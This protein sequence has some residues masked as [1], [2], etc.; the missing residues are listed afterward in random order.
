MKLRDI[1]TDP[2]F[3]GLHWSI[4]PNVPADV[5]EMLHV[6]AALKARRERNRKRHVFHPQ[7]LVCV[8]CNRT[9]LDVHANLL[10]CP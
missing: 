8:L 9:A 2:D 5:R 7:T 10:E 1:L 6:G 3:A 4:P